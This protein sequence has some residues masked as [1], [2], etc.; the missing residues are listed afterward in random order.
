MQPSMLKHGGEARA[1]CSERAAE[2]YAASLMAIDPSKPAER[3]YLA[4]L[5]ARLK[6]ETGLVEHLHAKAAEVMPTG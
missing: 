3:G 1:A 5:A 2:I 4:M 6:L